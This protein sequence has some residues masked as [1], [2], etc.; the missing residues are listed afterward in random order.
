MLRGKE[1]YMRNVKFLLGNVEAR[2][3]LWFMLF[4]YALNFVSVLGS[5]L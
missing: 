4:I 3:A 1:S 5:I 2:L